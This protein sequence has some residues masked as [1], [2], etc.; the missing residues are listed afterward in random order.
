MFNGGEQEPQEYARVTKSAVMRFFFGF[1]EFVP[2]HGYQ[3]VN[4][5]D[6]IHRMGWVEVF[7]ERD[8]DYVRQVLVLSPGKEPDNNPVGLHSIWT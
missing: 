5:A 1:T 7:R 8:L 3:R 6:N 2:P 4:F